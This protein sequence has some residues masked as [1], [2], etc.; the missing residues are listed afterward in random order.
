MRRKHGTQV[1]TLALC[2]AIAA[3]QKIEEPKPGAPVLVAFDVIDPSGAVMPLVADGGQVLVPPRAHVLARFDRL[4]DGAR[5]ESVTDAGVTG[6][7]GVAIITATG[8]PQAAISYIPNGDANFGLLF[9]PGPQLIVTP[10]PT[11][12][13]GTTITVTLDKTLIVSKRGEGPYQPAPGVADGLTF[14]T[15]PFAAAITA[16]DGA[17]GDGGL[18]QLAANAPVTIVFNNLPEAAIASRFMVV[19]TDATGQPLAN[20]AAP[21]AASEMDPATWVVLPTGG[22]WPAGARVSVSVDAAAQ[23]AL[24]MPITAAA[25]N[26]FAVSP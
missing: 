11:F 4:L 8:Q 16:G 19:V 20:A 10:I 1:V 7:P 3:C 12:P 2:A 18:P 22:A 15:A 9:P 26:T 25:T 24:G 5:L 21:P 14:T 6:K 13:A 23:D 17:P